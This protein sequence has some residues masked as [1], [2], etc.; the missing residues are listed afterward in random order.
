[1]VFRPKTRQANPFLYK[2][3][4]CTMPIFALLLKSKPL[5]LTGIAL[6]AMGLLALSAAWGEEWRPDYSLR[7]R[8][9]GP[10]M[11]SLAKPEPPETY[12]LDGPASPEA[13]A[14]WLG[15]L[16]QWRDARRREIGFDDAL[17]RRPDLDW[18]RQIFTQDQLL[19]WDRSLYDPAKGEYTVDRA[20]EGIESRFGPLDSVLLWPGYPNIGL[21]DRNQFDLLRDMPGGVPKLRE[22]VEAFHRRG[23]RVFFPVVVWD[24]GTREEGKSRAAAT[25]ELLHAIGA[26]GINFD[27]LNTVPDEARDLAANAT[28]PLALEPQF[29]PQNASLSASAISWDD[30]VLWDALPSPF[31]PRVSRVK[32][33]EPRHMVEVTDRYARFKIN[34]L[35]HA[36]FNGQGYALI[37]N[38]W[39]FWN[40]FSARDAE[41]VRRFTRIERAYAGL[42]ASPGWEPHTT[43]IQPGIFASR[44]PAAGQ[45]LWTFVNR[46]EYAVDGEQLAVPA[47]PGVRYFDLWHGRELTPAVR[48]G[49]AVLS[50]PF[51]ELGFGAVLADASGGAAPVPAALLA[52]AAKDAATPLKTFSLATP[53]APQTLVPIAPTAPADAAPPGMA[54]IPAAD[55]DFAVNGIEIENGDDPGVDVQFPWETCPRRNHRHRLPVARFFIDRTPVTNAGFKAFLDASH[56]RPADDHNFLRDWK[57]GT[58]PE[59]WA[60]K[61]VTWVALEDARA[62]AGGPANGCRTSGN[63]STR[64][65]GPTGGRIPGVPRGTRRRCRRRTTHGRGVRRLMSTPFP[66]RGQP[67]RGARPGRQRGAV[68]R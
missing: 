23:V 8:P 67:V 36:F 30:W 6:S 59:G 5:T 52:D 18:T 31:V 65:K 37:E 21:D 60:N 47:Q 55:Y 27:T 58:F 7:P 66:P 29:D 13:R 4:L 1:M 39:G 33:L 49:T 2:S 22:A 54:T 64:R 35:Q 45:T 48:N 40:G 46:N 42:L 51:E 62:Y 44:F 25:E 43:V 34:S 15:G 24:Q 57:D 38:F 10:G 61:P 32:W 17:Y 20:L 41:T 68:D 9:D 16:T 26:D 28:P 56:Y 63:G 14:A 12:L 11:E 19:V 3:T 53:F 50:F